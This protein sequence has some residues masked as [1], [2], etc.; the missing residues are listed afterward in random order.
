ML[1]YNFAYTRDSY[2][3]VSDKAGRYGTAAASA[4]HGS[5]PSFCLCS[6]Q[7]SL[8]LL[9]AH[10]AHR[11]VARPGRHDSIILSLVPR[12]MWPSTAH[13]EFSPAR[14]KNITNTKL[15]IYNPIIRVIE[16]EILRLKKKVKYFVEEKKCFSV[17]RRG[18]IIPD[19][20]T[21]LDKSECDL[22]KL[23]LHVCNLKTWTGDTIIPHQWFSYSV[24]LNES[25][26]N[27][28]TVSVQRGI[29]GRGYC[30]IWK[31]IEI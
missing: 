24:P 27:V 9:R 15:F 12:S 21:M 2:G 28:L 6:A 3:L 23:F 8:P 31:N 20:I 7:L 29:A 19:L 13:F 26:V 11:P 4:R 1:A 22:K 18:A 17:V 16:S 5:W 10:P 30:A 25:R 14:S